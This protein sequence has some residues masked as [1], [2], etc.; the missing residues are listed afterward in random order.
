M[1][2]VNTESASV[3]QAQPPMTLFTAIRGIVTRV[4]IATPLIAALVWATVIGADA[5]TIIPGIGLEIR[6]LS[7]MGIFSVIRFLRTKIKAGA[8]VQI[9]ATI[10]LIALMLLSLDRLP[11]ISLFVDISVL[12]LMG[13]VVIQHPFAWFLLW[14][15][16]RLAS[17]SRA[18]TDHK[19]DEIREVKS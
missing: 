12:S 5:F 14:A 3:D 9:G 13:I 6:L 8:S 11:L 15:Y 16:G 10:I 19:L 1:S 17:R 7:L 18:A 4:A 2:E